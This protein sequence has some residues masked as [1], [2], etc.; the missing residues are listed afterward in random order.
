M[1]MTYS[2]QRLSIGVWRNIV[3]APSTAIHSSMS[4]CITVWLSQRCKQYRELVKVSCMYRGIIS[5]SFNKIYFILSIQIIHLPLLPRNHHISPFYV[6]PCT[7]DQAAILP[8]LNASIAECVFISKAPSSEYLPEAFCSCL[9]SSVNLPV[10]SAQKGSTEYEVDIPD[11]T[12]SKCCCAL[13]FSP[14]RL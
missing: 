14:L 8:F 10:A 7:A 2:S 3:V 6:I 1:L 9:F 4:S 11:M 13:V 5:P 12:T